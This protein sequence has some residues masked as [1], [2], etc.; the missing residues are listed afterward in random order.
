MS[1]DGDPIHSSHDVDETSVI[2][3]FSFDEERI[4]PRVP[5]EELI[6][7]KFRSRHQGK[8]SVL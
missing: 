6:F 1:D 4:V 8:T 2:L 7:T 3:L 5:T